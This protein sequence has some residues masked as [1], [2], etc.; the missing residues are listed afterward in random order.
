M[1]TSPNK[2]NFSS[3]F[4][5]RPRFAGV[6]SIVL[7][8]A[9]LLA[10]FS[11][12]VAQYPQITPPQVTVSAA[13]PGANAEV[14]ADSVAAPI[15]QAVNGV[16]N[17]LYMSSSS[18]ANG[19]YSLTV[20]FAVGTDPDIAQVQVQNRVQRAT[21]KLPA[22]V[23]QQ[24]VSVQTESSDM[25]GFVILRSPNGTHDRLYMSNYAYDYIQPSLERLPGV[26]SVGVFG[27]KYSM[28]VWMDADRIAAF[29]MGVDDVL[30]AIRQQN[31]QASPGSV[32]AVPGDGSSRVMYSLQAKGRLNDPADF[33]NIIVRSEGSAVVRLKDVA[34]VELGPDS[35]AHEAEYNG[36]T[37][38]GMRLTRTAGSNALDTMTQI[39]SELKELEKQ[40]PE[41]MEIVLPYDATAY[42]RTSINEILMTLGI[43]FLLV[44]LVCYLFL[45]DW[46]AT[47]IPLLA[48]PVSLLATFAVLL[49][50]G[51]TINTLTPVCAHSGDRYC[52]GRCHRGGGACA[53]PD[54]D[55]GAR[56]SGCCVP[57]DG[58]CLRRHCCNHAGAAFN[59]CSGRFCWWNHRQ[60][61]SA[62]RNHHFGVG[63]L[64]LRDGT[65]TQSGA[66]RH[67][68]AHSEK[69][70]RTP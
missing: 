40:F 51:Y 34:R 48:I 59:L 36:G 54:G 43:T 70:Q 45:Q 31:I 42:V 39:R 55:R 46:R 53:L 56:P 14:L 23:T 7:A 8:L 5:R 62:V 27:S 19:S 57:R 26:S 3:I 30:T 21:S 33:E 10:I 64:F 16:D 66:L 37:A 29:G 15:E 44:V 38:I 65:N 61:L 12:P 2:F 25:L 69:Q 1:K 35:Y 49:A 4:I 13:Y 32:G 63:S 6:I 60:N 24:G 67:D 18:A 68:P 11:L 52:G 58:G 41:D 47:L 22:E 20:T 9:G 50:F 28:R 17:M